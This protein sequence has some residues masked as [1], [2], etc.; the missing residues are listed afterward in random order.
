MS[1]DDRAAAGGEGCAEEGAHIDA[2]DR[3]LVADGDD[4]RWWWPFTKSAAKC[5]RSVNA[6]S[7]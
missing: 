3:V 5:S 2:G 4:V 1:Q 6:M 7:A